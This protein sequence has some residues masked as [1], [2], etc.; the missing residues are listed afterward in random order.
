ME[1]FIIDMLPLKAELETKRVLK[2]L[3]V[4]HRYLAELKGV[5]ESI[6]NES[7][8]INT[9]SLQE[10]KDSSEIENIVTTHDELFKAN[11]LAESYIGAAAK[12]VKSYVS[13]MEQG[14]AEISKGQ[15][16]SNNLLINMHE[17]LIGNNAGF[18]KLPGTELKNLTTGETVYTPPQDYE[19]IFS[20][21]SNLEKYINDDS[22]SDVDAL[23]KMSVIHYQFESIHPFYDGNGRL[24]RILNIL[25]LVQKGLLQIPVL[26]LSRYIIQNKA[27]YYRLLQE[28]RDSNNWED[29]I[30]FMLKGVEEISLQGITL[31]KSIKE[32]MM[33]Y[34][35]RIRKDLP[36]IYS[37][38]LINNLFKHP[39]TKIDF[40]VDDL[41]VTRKTARNYLEKLS[42]LNYLQKQKIGRSNYYI[43]IP[44]LDLFLNVNKGNI[45]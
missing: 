9:L 40:L 5:A 14:F 20:L 15:I 1:K 29:F 8:I 39:Y 13:A 38:D 34:K 3:S 19:T 23:I 32:L 31:I 26:Y 33:D 12:E 44:L 22:L 16:L 42:D 30:L 21:M 6:P 18:R 4:A 11:I 41:K 25:Y 7:I 35:H 2:Q 27:D 24:G 45:Q 37:Q 17:R 28:I 10:A 43:N 36:K